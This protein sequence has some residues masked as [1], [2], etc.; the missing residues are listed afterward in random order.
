[1]LHSSKNRRFFYYRVWPWNLT[2]DLEK[3]RA[4]LLRNFKHCA[5]SHSHQW[6][7]TGVTVRKHQMRVKIGDFCPLWPWNLTDDLEKR[8]DTS[9]K[10]HQALCIISSPYVNSYWSNSPE[11][12]KLV[13]DLYGV[14][15]WP[16]TLLFCMDITFVYGNYTWKFHDDTMRRTLSKMCDSRTERRTDGWTDRRTAWNIHRAAWS[17]L[18]NNG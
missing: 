2:D 18:K 15:L 14:Y 12:A 10:P 17:Q 8:L 3:N 1:M 4:P 7:K 16:L 9:S 5:S 13:F 6:I 11:T